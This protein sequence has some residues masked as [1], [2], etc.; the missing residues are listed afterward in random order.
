MPRLSDE[1]Y[2]KFPLKITARGA[3]LSSRAAHV[4][5]QIEQV[6]FT[7]PGERVFRPEFG[8]GVRSL[9]FEPNSP[10]L[11]EV[12]KQRLTASLAKAL[13]GEVNSNSLNIEV[14]ASPE[15]G[16]RLLIRISYSLAKIGKEEQHVFWASR[17]GGENGP[18]S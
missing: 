15:Y 2:L 5:E 8:L 12:A 13:Q 9:V 11:A 4:R 14:E 7:N 16:E 18:V 10:S 17:G 6:L 3:S 1:P